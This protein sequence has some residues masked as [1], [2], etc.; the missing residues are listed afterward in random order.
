MQKR[1]ILP[2]LMGALLLGACGGKEAPQVDPAI[3][4]EQARLAEEEAR[5]RA[6]EEARRR[7]E[8]ERR[9]KEEARRRAEAAEAAQALEIMQALVHFDYD[10][11]NIR[12]DAEQRLMEKV[13]VLRANPNVRVRIEG[14][15]DE[16]GSDEYNLALGLRRANAV[17]DF[18]VNYGIDASRFETV[19]FGEERPLVRASNEDAWAMNRRAEFQVVSGDLT[20]APQQ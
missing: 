19:S 6:E 1:I 5:R 2:V 3:E 18:L 13:A 12:P 17:R 8:E 15:A 7:A 16:R 20:R 10:R 14:H 9:R 4:A 11:Y